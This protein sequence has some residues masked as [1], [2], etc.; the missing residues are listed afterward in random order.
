MRQ[1]VFVYSSVVSSKL[2]AH[3]PI[4]IHVNLHAHSAIAYRYVYVCCFSWIKGRL[5]LW[6]HGSACISGQIFRAKEKIHWTFAFSHLSNIQSEGPISRIIN[7]CYKSMT[8]QLRDKLFLTNKN[9]VIPSNMSGI[10]SNFQEIYQ[11][12][13]AFHQ[14]FRKFIEYSGHFIK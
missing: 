14:I 12:F 13:R 5:T 1:Y 7:F 3:K 4:S 11:I 6:Q 2:L 8:S 10:S 9:L